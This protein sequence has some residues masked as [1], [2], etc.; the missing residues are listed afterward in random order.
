MLQSRRPSGDVL[1]ATMG[2]TTP[3]TRAADQSEIGRFWLESAFS[4]PVRPSPAC[5]CSSCSPIEASPQSFC[6]DVDRARAAA[7]GHRLGRPVPDRNAVRA[8]D[9]RR[10]CGMD[11]VRT[12]PVAVAARR[13]TL[14]SPAS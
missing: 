8:H 9:G 1:F 12:H 14:T 2:V 7:R 4:V 3:T 13:V 5:R 11:R 10:H 6:A